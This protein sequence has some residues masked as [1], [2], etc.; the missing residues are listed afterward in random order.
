MPRYHFFFLGMSYAC[1]NYGHKDIDYKSYARDVNTW[2]R[3]SYENSRYQGKDNFVK[4][5]PTTLGSTY[6][7]FGS[8]IHEIEGYR[9]HNFGQIAKNYRNRFTS[10]S[11]KPR[12]NRKIPKQQIN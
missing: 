1:N 3:S 9:C 6:N 8:L 2:R 5:L 7:R 12:E 10:S 11:S 4:K